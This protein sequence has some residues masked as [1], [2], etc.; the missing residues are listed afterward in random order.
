MDPELVEAARYA[1]TLFGERGETLA[2]AE[3]LTGGLL[4]GAITAVPGS[5]EVYL[6][7]VVSYATA[8]KVSVLGVPTTVVEHDGVVSAA[9]AE[10][11]AEGVRRLLGADRAVATTGVAG[12]GS[13]DGV[14]A[15]TVWIAIAGPEGT[16]SRLF[17]LTG[18]R[19]TVRE[20]AGLAA[21]AALIDFL[22]TA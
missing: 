2:T 3:S 8:V 14:L 6:G 12:P 20:Q 13:Q 21:M 17:T 19:E 10:S 1:L 11:M 9:C 5:S 16:R 7:G 4:G 22:P 15:G 18:D